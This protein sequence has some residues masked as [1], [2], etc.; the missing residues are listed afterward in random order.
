MTD[1]CYDLSRILDGRNSFNPRVTGEVKTVDGH[2]LLN[3]TMTLNGFILPFLF[4]FNGFA[5][6]MFAAQVVPGLAMAAFVSALMLTVGIVLFL[7]MPGFVSE[8]RTTAHHLAKAVDATRA[9]L[10]GPPIERRWRFIARIRELEG[11]LGG[12]RSGTR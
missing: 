12:D 9:Q 5:G 6:V 3:G 8:A 10:Y 2:A 1:N 7:Q 4:F 11:S